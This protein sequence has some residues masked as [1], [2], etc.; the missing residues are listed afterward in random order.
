MQHMTF[1]TQDFPTP[2][3]RIKLFPHMKWSN[4]PSICIAGALADVLSVPYQPIRE[5]LLFAALKKAYF[6]RLGKLHKCLTLKD[7]SLILVA[8]LP[9]CMECTG[10]TSMPANIVSVRLASILRFVPTLSPIMQNCWI[11]IML[12]MLCQGLRK[13]SLA[14]VFDMTLSYIKARMSDQMQMPSL[15]LVN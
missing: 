7:T 1:R 13:V 9:T 4:S 15:M 6:A 5:S 8:P 3:T 10:V 12:L 2:N 11:F 14:A